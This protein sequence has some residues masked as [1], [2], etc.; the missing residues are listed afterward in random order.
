MSDIPGYTEAVQAVA[1]KLGELFPSLSIR[2]GE[3][4]RLYNAEAILAAAVP[5]IERAIRER[6]AAEIR[7]RCE[8]VYA[9]DVFHPVDGV[10]AAL[11]HEAFDHQGLSV[12][13]WSGHIM[14]FAHSAIA[15]F[16]A[17]GGEATE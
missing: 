12:D 3:K 10:E 14:R 2:E 13:A 1:R 5:H 6:V 16:V 15:D 7:Q 11:V 9:R 17:R 8:D 4:S